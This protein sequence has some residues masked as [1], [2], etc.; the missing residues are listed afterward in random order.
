M[1]G[2]LAAQYPGTALEAGHFIP[3]DHPTG[4]DLLLALNFPEG[5]FGTEYM[6]DDWWRHGQGERLIARL[7]DRKR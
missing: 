1:I 2:L 4:A 7:A 5:A 6:L 3:S